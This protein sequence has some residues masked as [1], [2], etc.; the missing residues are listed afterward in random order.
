MRRLT[1]GLLGL[2]AA[3]LVASAALAHAF[4][5]AAIPSVGGIVS[6][7]PREIRLVFSEGVEPAFSGIEL[8]TADGQPVKTGRAAVDPRD[9][10]QLVL[11]VPP[12][13]PGR[14][15]VTWHVVSV[16]T[17]RT[18]GDYVFEVKP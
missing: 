18:E 11:P 3:G 17:H 9:N 12:L 1:I 7:P 16:D 15:K 5:N 4:L 10:T 14:Y 2:L 13:G 8:A 6:A